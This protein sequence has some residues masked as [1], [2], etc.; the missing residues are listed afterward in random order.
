MGLEG[1]VAQWESQCR[2]RCNEGRNEC[3]ATNSLIPKKHVVY[4]SLC[5]KGSFV[6]GKVRFFLCYLLILNVGNVLFSALVT[7]IGIL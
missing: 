7:V 6:M 2:E 3:M 4:G 5:E 1:G